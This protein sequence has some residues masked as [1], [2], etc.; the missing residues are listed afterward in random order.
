[1]VLA[2]YIEHTL[3]K[4]EATSAQIFEACQLSIKHQFFG[5]C[6]N[7]SWVPL[8]A[9]TLAG[10]NV[11]LVAA[12]GFPLGAMST[13]TKCFEAEWC[14]KNGSAE[15]DMVLHL[16]HLRDRQHQLAL[17]DIKEVVSASAGAKV[18]VIIETGLLSNEEKLA[19]S[20]ICVDAGASFVKTCTGFNIGTATVEDVALIKSVVGEHLGIKASG[21][22]K[23]AQQALALIE[24]GATR[25]GT[26]SGPALVQGQTILGGY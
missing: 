25:I 12:I 24:A 3:L 2:T 8:A 23:K 17:E 20:Q 11:K 22:I 15:V 5:L 18:K 6:V 13:K 26:G 9:D 14:V 1:M 21:G 10:S 7:S 16:G 4:P 19:A